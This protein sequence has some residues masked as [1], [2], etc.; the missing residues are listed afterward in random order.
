MINTMKF[1][2]FNEFQPLPDNPCH[3]A[4]QEGHQSHGH[5]N[6]EMHTHIHE[7]KDLVNANTTAFQSWKTSTADTKHNESHTEHNLNKNG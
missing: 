3:Q 4:N 1:M 7:P 2:N 5:P 6:K